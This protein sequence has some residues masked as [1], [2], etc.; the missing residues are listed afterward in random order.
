MKN[1]VDRAVGRFRRI[2]AA[3]N[4]AGTEGTP[5]P[6][7]EVTGEDYQAT[8]DTNAK[9]TLLCL[10]HEFRVMREQGGGS[11][12]NLHSARSV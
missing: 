6:V 2:D 1:L 4:N 5:G 10:K 9:G 8:F 11:I 12:V 7:A 3:F